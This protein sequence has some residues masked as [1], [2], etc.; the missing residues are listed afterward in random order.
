MDA[1]RYNPPQ[2]MFFRVRL[3]LAAAALLCLVPAAQAVSW[4]QPAASLARQIAA[5]AGPG[6]VKLVV[7]NS[8]AVA[9]GDVPAIRQLL[10]R[11]LRGYG[12][13]A[14]GNES[15]TVVRVTLSENLE[16]GLWVAEVLEGSERRVTMLAVNLEAPGAAPSGPTLTLR[17]TLLVSEP[18]PIL[19]AAIFPEPGEQ[20]LVVLEPERLMVLVHDTASL[21]SA[22]SAAPYWTE[23]Q[24]FPIAHARPYPRDVRGRIVAAA[25]ATPPHL[26]DAYLP[27]VM[28][29]GTSMGGRLEVSCADSDDPWPVSAT[30]HAFYNSM[31][32][33]F[34]G[35]LAPGFGMELAPFYTAAELPR[36]AGSAL[37]LNEVNG[38]VVL[39]ENSAA[40]L[41]SGTNGWGSDFA[42]I[43]S[44]CGSGAQVLVSGSGPAGVGDTLSAFEIPGRDAVPVSAALPIEGGIAAMSTAP[45]GTTATM[46][47][48]RDGATR[49]E[50]WNVAA[51]CN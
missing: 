13:V 23:S 40:A 14:G 48:R 43:R 35:I 21:G 7:R 2:R 10:E 26:F 42:V 22:G 37:L 38:N 27:G 24:T 1:A 46:I 49:Y 41:V 15:A 5:L 45:D 18:D 28:C 30:Q 8:S 31:R 47:V 16:G 32:D 11:E 6:E 44:G 50:V 19:D 12:I 36:T 4:D 9:A 29:S 17:R 39:I 20:R 33:Y 25:G 34:T 3:F 51:L